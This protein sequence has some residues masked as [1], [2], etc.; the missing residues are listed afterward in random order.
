MAAKKVGR[1]QKK[2]AQGLFINSSYLRS[3]LLKTLLQGFHHD[4][5]EDQPAPEPVDCHQSSC[6]P[7][8][9]LERGEG[10]KDHMKRAVSI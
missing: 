2:H 4:Q 3:G 9:R 8:L 7:S 1:M 10:H 5:G 6:K